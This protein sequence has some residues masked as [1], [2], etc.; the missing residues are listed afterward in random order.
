MGVISWNGC[1]LL[2]ERNAVVAQKFI[3]I[4]VDAPNTATLRTTPS[5]HAGFI[6]EK[7]A[8]LILRLLAY[9]VSG[10]TK[11]TGRARVLAA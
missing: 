7:R 11:R 8:E 3:T 1:P 10:S 6:S 5:I 2:R 4:R 9:P